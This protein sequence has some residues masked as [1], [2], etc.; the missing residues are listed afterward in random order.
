MSTLEVKAIQAPTG[1][2]LQ[3]PAG[4]IL[5][6]VVGTYSTQLTTTSTSLVD[7]GLSAS[8]TPS[9]TNS[10]ILIMTQSQHE[11]GNGEGIGVALFR[12]STKIFETTNYHSYQGQATQINNRTPYL[13]LDSPSST[14][15]I[16]YKMQVRVYSG[17]VIFND[18]N[19]PTT[20]LLQE[21]AG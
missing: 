12:D 15:S 17:S 20:I 13:Y 3:M 11:I 1:Y 10:K 2:D 4:H 6:T 5:Q 18:A 21:V 16:T 7:L 8:I 9:S 14:S 19:N